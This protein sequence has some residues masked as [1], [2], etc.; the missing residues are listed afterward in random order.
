M[1][2][3]TTQPSWHAALEGHDIV[4][5]SPQYWGDYWVSKHWMAYELS[6]RLRTV[7]I[8]PPTW[9]GGLIRSPWTQRAHF[10]RLLQPLRR[11]DRQLCVLSPKF[12]PRLIDRAP[13]AANQRT[14]EMLHSMGIRRPIV[15]NF[16]T[17]FD[18]V[19]RLRGAVTVYYCVDPPFPDAGEEKHQ[20][21]TC[22]ASDL[23]YAVSDA[24]R[25]QLAP[26]CRA[27][28][29]HVIPHGYAF[30]HARRIDDDSATACPQEMKGLP[31]PILG[32]VGSI[33][34]EYVD[35]DRI[36]Q[37]AK[38]RPTSSIVLIGPY[39]NNPLGRD[40]SSD[41]LRR[42]RHL[43]NVYLLGPRHFLDVP[44]YVKY[45]DVCLLLVNVKDYGVS[46]LTTQR[47]HFK[48]LAY[49]AM[50]KPVVAPRVKE[51][52]SISSLVYLT[53]D[54]ESYLAAI[55]QALAE[56]HTRAGPR[57]SYASEFSFER[58]LD[59]IAGPIARCLN[60]APDA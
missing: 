45:F 17:N 30:G 57:V 31:R 47:T 29:L 58:T 35:L 10:R 43:P 20:A 52:E 55:D 1:S 24:Y 33:H 37:L 15:L 22:Q 36:E 53:S 48:W 59:S 9:V 7:F 2:Y 8:E 19:T 54:D 28:Q 56:D 3:E 23:V 11:I 51:A 16:G 34:D 4:I 50:G 60:R 14:V 41:A 32:Y 27:E 6:R 40:L 12:L 13:G 5:I 26:L 49:L 18:L 44:R 38:R 46:A 25:Q 42:L 21:L 39:R